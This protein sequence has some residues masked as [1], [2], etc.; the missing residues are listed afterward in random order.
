MISPSVD[1]FLKVFNFYKLNSAKY[2]REL[3]NS[4]HLYMDN[5]QKYF[6]LLDFNYDDKSEGL[7]YPQDSRAIQDAIS[8]RL[9][10][11]VYFERVLYPG[12]YAFNTTDNKLIRTMLLDWGATIKT[13]QDSTQ[14][15]TDVYALDSDSVDKGIKGFG[16]DFI[17]SRTVSSLY[18]RQTFL[19]NMCE[20][21]KIKG[22]P[23][24]ILKALRIIG[25][26]A[27]TI[28][29][30]WVAPTRD[31]KNDVEIKWVPVRQ[32]QKF[33]EETLSY[34][35]TLDKEYEYWSWGTFKDKISKIGECH[36][37]YTKQEI[38]ELNTQ[39]KTFM[40]LPSI[41]PYFDLKIRYDA[42]LQQIQNHKLQNLTN[43]QFGSY[44]NNKKLSSPIN[45]SGYNNI[46]VLECYLSI[47]YILMK[48]YDAIRYNSLLSYINQNYII[49]VNTDDIIDDGHKYLQLIYKIYQRIV[50]TKDEKT[51]RI[52]QS[53]IYNFEQTAASNYDC[54]Y[55]ELLSWWVSQEHTDDDVKCGIKGYVTYPEKVLKLADKNNLIICWDEKYNTGY[56]DIEYY[57]ED[58]GWTVIAENLPVTCEYM[59][60]VI[61][62]YYD[63]YK[64][65]VGENETI[66]SK[67]RIVHYKTEEN[68]PHIFLDKPFYFNNIRDT[69]FDRILNLD[70]SLINN[71]Y[72]TSDKFYHLFLEQNN[73]SVNNVDDVELYKSALYS[74]YKMDPRVTDR[75]LGYNSFINSLLMYPNSVLY[76]DKETMINSTFYEYITS[77]TYNYKDFISHDGSKLQYFN[78][79]K[80]PENKKWNWATSYGE[81]KNSSY[82]YLNYEAN[83]WL[84]IAGDGY[85]TDTNISIPDPYVPKNLYQT[86]QEYDTMTNHINRLNDAYGVA[87]YK[88]NKIYFKVC[89]SSNENGN[90]FVLDV[91]NSKNIVEKEWNALKYV[92]KTYDYDEE[93]YNSFK[94][95]Y[96]EYTILN[97]DRTKFDVILPP[98]DLYP[99]SLIKEYKKYRSNSYYFSDIF[100]KKNSRLA[101]DI[102]IAKI[103]DET[104]KKI[105]E[106]V[107]DT[108]NT[109]NCD[110]YFDNNIPANTVVTINIDPF[111][112]NTEMTYTYSMFLD[113]MYKNNYCLDISTG[114]IYKKFNYYLDENN[115]LY[116]KCI[117][118]DI[119]SDNG[120][121]VQYTWIRVKASL[122]WLN[123]NNLSLYSH[124]DEDGNIICDYDCGDIPKKLTFTN[125]Y[126][127]KRYLSD[128]VFRSDNEETAEDKLN[129]VYGYIDDNIN[130]VL[131]IKNG[132]IQC[133]TKRSVYNK[134][135]GKENNIWVNEED[136]TKYNGSKVILKQPLLNK[137]NFGINSDLIDYIDTQLMK[138]GNL[139][140]Y[141]LVLI[142]FLQPLNEYCKQ[143]LG[144]TADLDLYSFTLYNSKVVYNIIKFYKPKRARHLILST[145]IE[146]ELFDERY[147]LSYS[148][149]NYN[150]INF[151]NPFDRKEKSLTNIRSVI[152]KEINE[153]IPFDDLVFLDNNH[154]ECVY[155]AREI[156]DEAY[157]E[158]KLEVFDKLDDFDNYS[159]YI[160]GN[161]VKGSFYCTDFNNSEINGIYYK[162]DNNT[163]YNNKYYIIRK[164]LVCSYD[165]DPVTKVK[166][167]KPLESEITRWFI[168]SYVSYQDGKFEAYNCKYMST[169]N[170]SNVPYLD[171]DGNEMKYVLIKNGIVDYDDFVEYLSMDGEYGRFQ[172][173]DGNIFKINLRTISPVFYFNSFPVDKYNGYYYDNGK[174]FNGK[175]VYCNQYGM[176]IS[177]CDLS[178]VKE[179]YLL[180]TIDSYG[181]SRKYWILTNYLEIPDYSDAKFITS[182]DKDDSVFEYDLAGNS[183]GKTKM[184]YDTDFKLSMDNSSIFFMNGVYG[185][186]MRKIYENPSLVKEDVNRIKKYPQK[187][188]FNRLLKR[189][190]SQ[191]LIPERYTPTHY[192]S[193]KF[194]HSLR[195]FNDESCLEVN[196]LD[197][198]NNNRPLYKT[199]YTADHH[200]NAIGALKVNSN[201][202]LNINLKDEVKSI[203]I[204]SL[205]DG[206]WNLYSY[207]KNGDV[208]DF[209][210]DANFVGSLT[211]PNTIT[212][213]NECS[214]SEFYTFDY[215]IPEWYIK[216]MYDYGVFRYRYEMNVQHLT[217]NTPNNYEPLFNTFVPRSC[218]GK[219]ITG[220]PENVQGDR[221]SSVRVNGVEREFLPFD[222]IDAFNSYKWNADSYYRPDS[223]SEICDL[224][225]RKIENRIYDKVIV[226]TTP[227]GRITRLYVKPKLDIKGEPGN[228]PIRYSKYFTDGVEYSVPSNYICPNSEIPCWWTK[229]RDE[230]KTGALHHNGAYIGLKETLYDPYPLVGR[231]CTRY[232]DTGGKLDGY[233]NYCH[234]NRLFY[235]STQYDHNTRYLLKPNIQAD[236]VEGKP[237][238]NEVYVDI[239]DSTKSFDYCID[240]YNNVLEVNRGTNNYWNCDDDPITN[241]FYDPGYCDLTQ[242]M[243]D[244]AI[245]HKQ[246]KIVC[247][248]LQLTGTYEYEEGVEF[249][250]PDDLDCCYLVRDD[251]NYL[252]YIGNELEMVHYWEEQSDKIVL[253]TFTQIV[254][255]YNKDSGY[256]LWEVRRYKDYLLSDDSNIENIE[257]VIF[258][259]TSNVKCPDYCDTY[260]R[261]VIERE[262]VCNSFVKPRINI[263]KEYQKY[264][265][266]N[267][268]Q[269]DICGLKL[270]RYNPDLIKDLN[271]KEYTAIQQDVIEDSIVYNYENVVFRHSKPLT[272]HPREYIKLKNGL[273][274]QRFGLLNKELYIYIRDKWYGPFDVIKVNPLKKLNRI[275]CGINYILIEDHCYVRVDEHKWVEVG[276][277]INESINTSNI[278]VFE[279]YVYNDDVYVNIPLTDSEE[280]VDC[281]SY[282]LDVI[283]ILGTIWK[284]FKK[285]KDVR[286]NNYGK[287]WAKEIRSKKDIGLVR[288]GTFFD[289]VEVILLGIRKYKVDRI[290]ICNEIAQQRGDNN[291]YSIPVSV[292]ESNLC[293]CE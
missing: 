216:I 52:Y 247:D 2:V 49:K 88:D 127:A 176:M 40:H 47:V 265:F 162:I 105:Y 81:D 95:N 155:S 100:I 124:E 10:L 9:D 101:R 99:S 65:Y 260:Y 234:S 135:T 222:G 281:W 225:T 93:I 178:D 111:Y 132:S 186:T 153:Y 42:V 244:N 3:A 62:R 240:E 63:G 150:K 143:N 67:I 203:H 4:T 289:A 25:L 36:W 236:K 20:L 279:P 169:E 18:R 108:I 114:Y 121:Y 209:Y 91:N 138:T 74:I 195:D 68:I 56:Y 268:L 44:L 182:C 33:N 231:N 89:D 284:L 187:E 115:Y 219:C 98:S 262:I 229:D 97:D 84:R 194:G 204:R 46:S 197:E 16:I 41:T 117:N 275:A 177:Y 144:F 151:N 276:F 147:N 107:L 221:I 23:N 14:Q 285:D 55:K 282:Y 213:K 290:R 152:R 185:Y 26:D 59:E 154:N 15:C 287:P 77:Y 1:N 35:D 286:F 292:V 137:V 28:S 86:K 288:T 131:L 253:R 167:S 261:H 70:E 39:D 255:M 238:G 113:Y 85:I 79:S 160:N 5:T 69:E 120:E 110:E 165:Y 263:S 145:N 273:K 180:N 283:N 22:S 258:E 277:E 71:Y 57:L 112:S 13:F 148:D 80:Y 157:N 264:D 136:L 126:D 118:G 139:D 31:G 254:P 188:E 158:P 72:Y 159:Q 291:Y 267:Q 21:Y 210:L 293:P 200:C 215:D 19:L 201:C 207:V 161:E 243:K 142:D 30:C 199:D 217:Y 237:Y 134:A 43:L 223:P 198:N 170:I 246:I 53:I 76:A 179:D 133:K 94:K 266:I 257:N 90:Y 87:V 214:V 140:D 141:E 60:K 249:R 183:T 64:I 149:M 270:C 78:H 156:K 12:S 172:I 164:T 205:V 271:E 109:K 103:N 230:Y 116:I 82:F 184:F 58:L 122:S 123:E 190:V 208:Y 226:N 232:S 196:I 220:L 272:K 24:S 256:Y 17:N 128:P 206:T 181:S 11:S 102:V 171:S 75:D 241:I 250:M 29:E 174:T 96:E 251:D 235:G 280:P 61:S 50:N 104:C 248:E 168:V 228:R 245:F 175:P 259:E 191:N 239:K 202:Q 189:R 269:L 7:K 163:Y 106:N 45:I 38:I 274:R 129:S 6:D 224:W 92:H 48:F 146:G 173:N 32:P 37:F 34:N 233:C 83:K 51:K 192:I 242:K 27:E 193:F 8:A 54:S 73:N 211:L 218:Y 66:E 166:L 252:N 119:I 212:L 125:T 227:N 278:N 130:N